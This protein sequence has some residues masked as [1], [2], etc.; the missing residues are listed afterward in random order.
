E[1]ANE[2]VSV[3]TK[4]GTTDVSAYDL[5]VDAYNGDAQLGYSGNGASGDINV[6]LTHNLTVRA[7]GISEGSDCNYYAM[8]GNGQAENEIDPSGNITI[9]AG[10]NITLEADGELSSAQIGN[11]GQFSDADASGDIS[12]TAGGSLTMSATTDGASAQI[13]NGGLTAQGDF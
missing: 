6:S 3:G 9:T 13:G 4:K 5:T 7:P 1:N 8:I 10:N 12:V 11:G 2:D